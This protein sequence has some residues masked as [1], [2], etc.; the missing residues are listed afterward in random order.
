[1]TKLRTTTP[2]APLP[3]LRATVFALVGTVLGVSAHHLVAEGPMPW[4]QSVLAAAGLFGVGLVGTR[5]PRPLAAVVAVC[6]AAQAGLHTWLMAEHPAGTA[7]MTTP[8]PM[9]HGMDAHTAWHEHAHDSLAMTAVHAVAA[10]LVAVLLHRADVACWS[11]ARGLTTAVN[12]AR[13][14]VVTAWTLFSERLSPL[15]AGLRAL[16]PDWFEP[17]L[18]G[19]LLADVVVRRGPP[20]AG[21]TRAI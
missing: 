18:S 10:V 19:A 21:L 5:R 12:A 11:L 8:A 6:G 7:S 2:H 3:V 9:H 4:R 1:M 16:V 13:A 17:P 20:R 14:R 15:G